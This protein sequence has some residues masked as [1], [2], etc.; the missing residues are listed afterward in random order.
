MA[1][2]VAMA[3]APCNTE[4]DVPPVYIIYI[5]QRAGDGGTGYTEPVNAIR[6]AP[7]RRESLSERAVCTV[8]AG[9][10]SGLSAQ[11]Q[12]PGEGTTSGDRGFSTTHRCKPI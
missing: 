4:L 6:G 8:A 2:C 12:A 10:R 11:A 1:C 5:F 3:A 9:A 7:G